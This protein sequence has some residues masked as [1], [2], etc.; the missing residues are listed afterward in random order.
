MSRS[1]FPAPNLDQVYT[2]SERMVGRRIAGEF[3]LV[4]IVGRGADVEAIYNL[5]GLGAFVWE[6]LDGTS[7]GAAVVQAILSRYEVAPDTARHDYG[8][9]VRQ[10]QSIHAIEPMPAPSDP[11]RR[12]GSAPDGVTEEPT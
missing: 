6:R 7:S 1:P 12:P 3:V 2:R 11:G 5:N 8:V 10:L 4:P 9:F